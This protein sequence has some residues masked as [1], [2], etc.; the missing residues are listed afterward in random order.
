LS[1]RRRLRAQ[2]NWFVTLNDSRD[3]VRV[4]RSC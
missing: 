3:R 2:P 4:R 1:P